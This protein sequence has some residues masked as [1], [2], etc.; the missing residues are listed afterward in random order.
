MLEITFWGKSAAWSATEVLISEAVG[1]MDPQR[2][3]STSPVLWLCENGWDFINIQRMFITIANNK[4]Y[5]DVKLKAPLH[6]YNEADCSCCGPWYAIVFSFVLKEFPS[7]TT[8]SLLLGVELQHKLSK[9]SG[10]INTFFPPYQI[11]FKNRRSVERLE[12]YWDFFRQTSGK[13]QLVS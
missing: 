6:L 13:G 1:F 9:Q 10:N 3:L 4:T 2:S 7:R 12:T 8:C 5:L 11:Y